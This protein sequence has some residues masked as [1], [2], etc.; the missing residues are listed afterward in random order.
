MHGVRV[1]YMYEEEVSTTLEY[2]F[3]SEYLT[4]KIHTDFSYHAWKW[5]ETYS[6]EADGLVV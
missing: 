3:S 6:N 1:V 4:K 5:I 2:A